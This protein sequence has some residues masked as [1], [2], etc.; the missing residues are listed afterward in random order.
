MARYLLPGASKNE[1]IKIIIYKMM[2][3][4]KLRF[5]FIF[6]GF[7]LLNFYLLF[8]LDNGAQTLMVYLFV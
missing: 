4:H 8:F 7:F 3:A 6:G 5:Y 2:A 1:G